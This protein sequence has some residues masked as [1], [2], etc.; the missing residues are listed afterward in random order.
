[1]VIAGA[2]SCWP[3]ETVKACGSRKQQELVQHFEFSKAF[4]KLSSPA[5]KFQELAPVSDLNQP[6]GGGWSSTHPLVKG[7]VCCCPTA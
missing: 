5:R 7:L 2:S 1:M 4:F 6:V 3:R